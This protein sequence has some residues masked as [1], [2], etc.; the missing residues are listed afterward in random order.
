MARVLAARAN[1][2]PPNYTSRWPVSTEKLNEVVQAG[3]TRNA[4]LE[5]VGEWLRAHIPALSGPSSGAP[6]GKYVLREL[7]REKIFS[8]AG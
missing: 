3:R 4:N 5:G 1:G 8:L 6:W 7:S 2:E